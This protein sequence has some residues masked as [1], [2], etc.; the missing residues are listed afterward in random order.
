M[1][2]ENVLKGEAK[3]SRG[4][5][6]QIINNQVQ[7]DTSDGEYGPCSFTLKEVEELIENYKKEINEDMAL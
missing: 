1:N 4:S 6:I 7:F 3:Y 5:Y 2:V